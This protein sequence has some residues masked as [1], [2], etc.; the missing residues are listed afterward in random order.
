MNTI[1]FFT[2]LILILISGECFSKDGEMAFFVCKTVDFEVSLKYPTSNNLETISNGCDMYR[3]QKDVTLLLTLSYQPC[4]S[5][6]C[7]DIYGSQI[8]FYIE[9][10]APPLIDG[11]AFSDFQEFYA[12]RRTRFKSELEKKGLVPTTTV[13]STG[14]YNSPL[15]PWITSTSVITG[16]NIPM[17]FSFLR[18]VN[19]R[20][21]M[22]LSVDVGSRP[23]RQ[24]R[25]AGI[26]M[27]ESIIDSVAIKVIE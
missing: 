24:N 8:T 9:H 17:K 23:S 12:S 25:E 5:F 18:P 13:I 26:K 27:L 19:T 4:F 10:L 14:L 1:R 22:R 21:L 2:L 3:R 11:F 20:L 15:G 6:F 7:K 16:E